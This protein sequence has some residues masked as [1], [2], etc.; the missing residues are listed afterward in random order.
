VSKEIDLIRTIINAHR[1]THVR[2]K[3]YYEK[4][5]DEEAKYGD[6]SGNC[7][8][9]QV[10]IDEYD[11]IL[12]ALDT[13]E[14]SKVAADDQRTS[15]L[16]KVIGTW[17][18]KIFPQSTYRS[19]CEHLRREVQELRSA[20]SPNEEAADCLLLLLHL[21]HKNKF[22]LIA[23]TLKKHEINKQRKWGEPDEQGVVEHIKQKGGE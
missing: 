22:D 8:H 3:N 20:P 15:T 18:E 14:L 6:Y 9:Q 2:W 12:G 11:L 17:A 23:E 4:N 21:A 13:L 1:E 16:Q 10:C 5:P 19:I 7:A